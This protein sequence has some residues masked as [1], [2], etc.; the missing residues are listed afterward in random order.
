MIDSFGYASAGESVRSL[1]RDD[2]RRQAKRELEAGFRE[3]VESGPTVEMTRAEG[4]SIP[5]P[6]YRPAIYQGTRG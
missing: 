3:A 5:K 6:R 1:I 2:R 4:K